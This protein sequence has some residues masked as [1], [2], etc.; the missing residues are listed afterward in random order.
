[1]KNI[2]SKKLRDAILCILL[3]MVLVYFAYIMT[4]TMF[5][6]NIVAIGFLAVMGSIITFIYVGSDRKSGYI[7]LFFLIITS[8]LVLMFLSKYTLKKLNVFRI[9]PI[10][11]CPVAITIYKRNK[12]RNVMISC[13]IACVIV[14]AAGMTILS[15][16]SKINSLID[17]RGKIDR[18]VTEYI[19]SLGYDVTEKD[20]IIMFNEAKR[21]KEIH[22]QMYRMK[23]NAEY[24]FDR[25]LHMVYYKGKIISFEDK[26]QTQ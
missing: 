6:F 4:D 12:T 15:I 20:E 9:I 18:V 24:S 1:M 21:G 16:N 5:E 22:L 17:T 14:F 2:R 13:V 3:M 26:K 11:F 7:I 19:V 25:V 8:F 10:I 23:P